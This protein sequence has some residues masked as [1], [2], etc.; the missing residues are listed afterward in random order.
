M[1]FSKKNITKAILLLI[2]KFS[3]TNAITWEEISTIDPLYLY[4][5]DINTKHPAYKNSFGLSLSQDNHNHIKHDITNKMLLPDNSVDIY[6]SEDVFEHIEYERL[7]FVINDIFRVLKPGGLLRI[8][9]PDYRCDIL[10]NRSIKDSS[11]N[12]IFDPIGGGQYYNGKVING[13]HLWFPIFENM[14]N[15]LEK[16]LFFIHGSINFLHYYNI[17]NQSITKKIDYN[18]GYV[19]RTPDNDVRV[20]N[21]YRA[22]S[23]V[24]DLYK[25]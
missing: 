15:L 17:N 3:I 13:G 1:F 6:Q 24:V 7:V 18:L 11:G 25:E 8:S 16:T 22:M 5:G 12:I 10:Y 19:S 23:I 20:Q 9:V 4:A 14:M 21:P 2:C